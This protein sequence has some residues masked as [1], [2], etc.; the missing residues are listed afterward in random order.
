MADFSDFQLEPKKI[1]T[2]YDKIIDG[3][4]SECFADAQGFYDPKERKVV[5]I[6]AEDET[7]IQEVEMKID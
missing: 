7:H 6:C 4:C 5:L 2:I 1:K 3:S